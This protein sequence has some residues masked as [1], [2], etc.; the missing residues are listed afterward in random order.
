MGTIR[1]YQSQSLRA[2]ALKINDPLI[3]FNERLSV[4]ARGFVY[5][6]TTEVTVAKLSHIY[7][8]TRPD[9]L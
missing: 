9:G 6:Q 8:R 7:I 4:C 2:Q 5:S 1:F 3:E